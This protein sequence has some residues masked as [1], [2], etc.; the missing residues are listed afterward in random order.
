MC[1][2]TNMTASFGLVAASLTVMFCMIGTLLGLKSMR[3]KKIGKGL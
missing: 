3:E 1:I 2:P